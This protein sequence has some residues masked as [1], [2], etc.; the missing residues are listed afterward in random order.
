[1]KPILALFSFLLLTTLAFAGVVPDYMNYQGVMRRGD[2]TA[3]NAGLYTIEFRIY[4]AANDGDLLWGRVQQVSLDEEGH[5]NTLLM[6]GGSTIPATAHTNLRDVFIEGGDRFLELAMKG[7]TPIKPRQQLVSSPFAFL[8]GNVEQAQGDFIVQGSLTAVHGA[9]VTGA[10]VADTLKV[11]GE[12]HIDGSLTAQEAATFNKTLT[13]KGDTVLE[14][15]LT[16]HKAA[17]FKSDAEVE[18]KLTVHGNLIVGDDL[19]KRSIEVKSKDGIIK[20]GPSGWRK[21]ERAAILVRS[22][23][24][25]PAE[26][27]LQNTVNGSQYGWQISSREGKKPDLQ[28][29]AYT[30][31]SE[32]WNKRLTLSH[33]GK[34]IV[35]AGG[36]EVAGPVSA[37]RPIQKYEGYTS[38]VEHTAPSDGYLIVKGKV[39]SSGHIVKLYIN[40]ALGSPY[41]LWKGTSTDEEHTSTFPIAKGEKW[42]LT[43]DAGSF[44]GMSVYWRGIGVG[45]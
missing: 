36:L 17:T 14:G 27:D 4:D 41:A 11:E 18:K 6:S 45:K 10:L 43:W 1:M 44:S 5:F 12:S 20:I 34:L 19:E 28:F 39:K 8:A 29:Y 24:D 7:S 22:K 40:N 32:S 37:F 23:G 38:G 15:K 13:V 9:H 3:L 2:G 31:G 30:G 42:H 33:D 21:H 16:T 25:H 35:E 26:I